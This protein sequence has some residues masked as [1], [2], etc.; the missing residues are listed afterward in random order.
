MPIEQALTFLVHSFSPVL[1]AEIQALCCL[2]ASRAQSKVYSSLLSSSH[3]ILELRNDTIM[4]LVFHIT[5]FLTLCRVAINN[6]EVADIYARE[7]ASKVTFLQFVV[8][9]I[10]SLPPPVSFLEINVIVFFNCWPILCFYRW[11][12]HQ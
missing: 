3:C 9:V 8:N 6:N 11:R 10:W 7:A 12:K 5:I 1:A 4:K 2:K